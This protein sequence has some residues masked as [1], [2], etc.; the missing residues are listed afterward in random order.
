[1][2]IEKVEAPLISTG[3][4]DFEDGQGLQLTKSEVLSTVNAIPQP[5]VPTDI[6]GFT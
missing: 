1:M 2:F 3:C 6:T 5:I 4:S